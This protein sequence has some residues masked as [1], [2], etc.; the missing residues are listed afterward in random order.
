MVQCVVG[1]IPYGGPNELFL[2]PASAPQLVNK[3]C[4]LYYPVFGVVDIKDS[5]LLIKKMQEQV[6]S[7]PI[8]CPLPLLMA[9]NHK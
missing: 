2:V 7:L 4:G 9:Y 6:S 3:G 5:L 8:V 1:S